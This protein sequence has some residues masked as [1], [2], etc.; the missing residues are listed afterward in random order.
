MKNAKF[1]KSSNPVMKRFAGIEGRL[2]FNLE[3]QAFFYPEDSKKF[4]FGTSLIQSYTD[5]N[6]ILTLHTLNST[7]VFEIIGKLEKIITSE[8]TKSQKKVKEYVKNIKSKTFYCEAS[9]M[10]SEVTFNEAITREEA[11]NI[12]SSTEIRD[13]ILHQVVNNIATIKD[14]EGYLLQL[15]IS[16]INDIK[17]IKKSEFER[18]EL[19]EV[20]DDILATR[21]MPVIE[22]EVYVSYLDALEFFK[23]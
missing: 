4:L 23:Y 12:I 8:D 15:K 14:D 21:A 9:G 6:N 2:L 17:F 20:L 18:V 19:L 7:Y 22:D 16:V 11:L 1:I 10:M 13:D 5:E 3:A